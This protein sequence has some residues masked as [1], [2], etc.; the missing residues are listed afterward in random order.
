MRQLLL[1]ATKHPILMI[2]ILFLAIFI[3]RIDWKKH[4]QAHNNALKAHSCNAVLIPLNRRIPQT[5]K[6]NC[7]ENDLEVTT[8]LDDQTIDSVLKKVNLNGQTER[9][10]VVKKIHYKEL[11]NSLVHISRQS[12]NYT[13]ERT[14]YVTVYLATRHL[15]LAAYTHGKYLFKLASLTDPQM[16]SEHLKATV[17]IKESSP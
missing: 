5:W 11:A 4:Y 15:K 2:G 9:E 16:I 6:A 14:G 10:L 13:L 1:L 7:K 3:M 17:Q 12:P 8:T